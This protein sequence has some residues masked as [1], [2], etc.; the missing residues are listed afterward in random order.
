MSMMRTFIAFLTYG[1]FKTSLLSFESD[2][3]L[4]FYDDRQTR[5]EAFS[6]ELRGVSA[7]GAPWVIR[8]MIGVMIKGS[9]RSE[10]RA[11][12]YN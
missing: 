2:Q 9:L 3:S 1:S 8:A 6:Q 10:R 7:Q 12:R 4:K 11:L 5:R